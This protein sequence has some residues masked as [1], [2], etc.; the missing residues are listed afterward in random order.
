MPPSHTED[1]AGK[2]KRHNG[3]RKSS[4]RKHTSHF[5]ATLMRTPFEPRT[6]RRGNFRCRCV[7]LLLTLLP[8]IA[9][10]LM[11]QDVTDARR[12]IENATLAPDFRVAGTAS[13]AIAI[14]S[15]RRCCARTASTIS[16]PACCSISTPRGSSRASRRAHSSRSRARTMR[17]RRCRASGGMLGD[18]AEGATDGS[19]PNDLGF[20]RQAAAFE[21][22]LREALGK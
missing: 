14:S 7:A 1:S 8:G 17:D 2:L 4:F 5:A 18:D 6:N 21:P 12:W 3:F 10:P 22:V 16:S 19:H 15:R 9:H 20:M 11:S 13:R